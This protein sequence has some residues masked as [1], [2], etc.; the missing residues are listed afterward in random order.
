MSSEPYSFIDRTER[1][2][3]VYED[4]SCYQDAPGLG[5]DLEV[6][7]LVKWGNQ[8]DHDE[9]LRMLGSLGWDITKGTALAPSPRDRH[10]YFGGFIV[11]TA[12]DKDELSVNNVDMRAALQ[13]TGV[14]FRQDGTTAYACGNRLLLTAD[15]DAD[16]IVAT[17]DNPMFARLHSVAF[18][19]DGERLLTAS[20]SL[21]MV[22]ELQAIDGEVVWSLDLWTET[23]HNVNTLGQS[24]Y[25]KQEFGM[26]NFYLNPSSFDLKDNEQMRNAQCVVDDVSAY[27]GLGLATALTPVFINTIDYESDQ[28]ILATSFGKGEAWRIDRHN[29]QIE[30]VAR[31]LGR[32][33]GF[34]VESTTGYIISD[35][36]RERVLLLSNDLK[37]EMIFDLSHLQGRKEGLEH[38]RWLQYTTEVES[39]LYCAVMTSRQVLTLFDPG[40][41][42]RRDITVDPDWGVQMVVPR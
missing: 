17:L 6:T 37:K 41:R 7:I 11:R 4:V 40:K 13:P 42:L 5:S 10:R 20:S 18:N 29:R 15:G 36:L 1:E 9:N 12:L 38:S 27:N 33:H 2:S 3:V 39:G 16:N 25:R 35:T 30:V 21:D 14:D 26:T 22:Y 31:G 8:R 24:F 28:I 32:P 19:S 23:P 34:H